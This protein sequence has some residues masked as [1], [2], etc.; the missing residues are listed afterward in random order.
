[1]KYKLFPGG[2]APERMSDG[3]AGFDVW[4]RSV[5]LV[6]GPHV[7]DHHHNGCS[8]GYVSPADRHHVIGARISLGF[9]IDTSQMQPNLHTLTP[10]MANAA[11]LLPRSGWGTKYG[12][13][14]RNTA[15]VIDPDYRG[16]VVMVAEFDEC[17]P[18]LLAFAESECCSVCDC[19]NCCDQCDYYGIGAP[20]RPRVGQ[21]LIVPCYVGELQQVDQLDDTSRGAGG[22]GSTGS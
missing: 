1:M 8:G 17:P 20:G 18:E 16:E 3:A 4:A 5:E 19:G 2:R 10:H 7:L 22:F 9:A 14:L 21:M 12:F 6:K 13:R 11:V 15:G